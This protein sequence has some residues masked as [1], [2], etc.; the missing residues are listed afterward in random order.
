MVGLRDTLPETITTERLVLTTPV[1][2]HAPDMAEL[3]NNPIIYRVLARLPHPYELEHARVFIQTIARGSENFAWAILRDGKFLGVVGLHLLPDELPEL[4]YWLGQPFWG[5]GYAT[6][7]ATA[8]VAAA[9][10][11]GFPALRSRALLSN[12]GSR[13]VLRKVG[14]VETGQGIDPD[15]TLKGRPV[16]RLLLEFAL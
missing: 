4:G 5:H 7:A 16:A 3:A 15:G 10:A 12:A 9:R 8:V 13:N 14:F 1:L 2:A 6:E 11:A